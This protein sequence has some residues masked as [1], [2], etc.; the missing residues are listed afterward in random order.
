[1]ARK[2]FRVVQVGCGGM[3]QKWARLACESRDYDL[4]GLVDL[5]REAAEETARRNGLEPGVVYDTLSAALK[6]ARPDVVFDVTVPEAHHK[7]V[8]PALKAGCHVLGE[9]PMSD[10]LANAKKMVAAAK[11]A[12]RVY[13]VTQTQRNGNAIRAFAKFCQGGKIGDIE[14]VHTDFFI[15][16]HFGGFRDEMEEVLLRDMS[17]HHFDAARKVTG[18]DPVSVYCE[19]FNPKRSWY[20]GNASAVAIFE[21]TD[22]MRYSYRGSWCAE[23]MNTGWGCAWRVYGSKGGATWHR[24]EMKAERVKSM[25]QKKFVRDVEELAIPTVKLLPEAHEGYLVEFAKCLRE[26]KLPETHCEDNIKS[27][28]MV[29]AAVKSAKT[30]RRVKVEW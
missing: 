15:G 13:A 11:A 21:M 24:N 5:R 29:A 6:G 7:V 12:G 16:A 18:A 8:I 1:M 22:G 9:K 4:V 2:A 17:I 26:G 3:A 23:G 30:G 19:S 20:A 28:A 14:E 27:L 25:R 10:T